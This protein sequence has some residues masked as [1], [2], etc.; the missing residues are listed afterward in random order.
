M[1]YACIGLGGTFDHFHA[2]H[3]AF[4]SFA[5]QLADQ[6]L[7]GVTTPQLITHK[8]YPAAIQS[9][10]E[11]EAAVGEFCT[12]QGISATIVHL[13]DEFGPTITANSPVQ[14]IAVTT[15]TEPGGQA[16]N[17]ERTH[18][19]LSPLPI[20]V[21]QLVPDEL[22]Q[23][24]TSTRI[25]AGQIDRQGRIYTRLLASDLSLN[26]TQ[27]AHFAQPQGKFV[28]APSSPNASPVFVVGD[29]CLES[30][31][32]QNWPFSLGV[33]DE[34]TQ[35]SPVPTGTLVSQ[36][37]PARICTN[38]RGMLSRQLTAVLEEWFAK[39]F[40][41]LKVSGEEDL[42]AVGLCL[43]APLGATIYYGQ[44]GQGMVE[45][46]VTE[47]AKRRCYDILSGAGQT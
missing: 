8:L 2:G 7:I 31:L 26:Q 35:R 9:L 41:T 43:L 36:L 25:R 47:D 27:R 19:Q 33:Y 12:S 17:L 24:I 15:Q 42:A 11:R 44:T 4:I 37:T 38:P 3:R 40:T 23:P 39:P 32:A 13:T 6:L 10:A 21:C 18:R 5:A 20:H 30:F 14:A 45:M 16:L 22:G 28:T 1:Q 29:V 46:V 34:V